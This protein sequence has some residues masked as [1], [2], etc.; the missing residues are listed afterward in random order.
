[1]LLHASVA[2]IEKVRVV[3]QPTVLSTWLTLTV[4]VL[5]VSVT[6]TPACTAA[7]VGSVPAAGLQPRSVPAG[8]AVITGAMVSALQV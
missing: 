5:H 7:S 8:A 3:T 2:L 4:A 6:V 1:V